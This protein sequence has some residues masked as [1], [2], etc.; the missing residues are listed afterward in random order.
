MGPK[1]PFCKSF[2][3]RSADSASG[4]GVRA[5][6][7]HAFA[8]LQFRAGRGRLP[9]GSGQEAELADQ[10]MPMPGGRARDHGDPAAGDGEAGRGAQHPLE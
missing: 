8:P 6:G 4:S 5:H 3:L 1:T 7:C 2:R 9:R 10:E